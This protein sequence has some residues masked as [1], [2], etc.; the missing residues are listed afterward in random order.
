MVTVHSPS[1]TSRKFGIEEC[2]LYT[3]VKGSHCTNKNTITRNW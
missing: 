2:H 3:D 1:H